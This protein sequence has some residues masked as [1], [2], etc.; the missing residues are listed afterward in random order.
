MA[1]QTFKAALASVPDDAN[2]WFEW[3]KLLYARARRTSEL[4]VYEQALAKFGQAKQHGGARS[5]PALLADMG[6]CEIDYAAA[7]LDDAQR[8]RAN[9]AATEEKAAL[10]EAAGQLHA[11]EVNY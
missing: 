1:E 3:G 8:V 6:R 4:D 7:L 11:S 5:D 9:A 2:T 10:A